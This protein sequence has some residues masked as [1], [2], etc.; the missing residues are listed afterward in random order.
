MNLTDYEGFLLEPVIGN[1]TFFGEILFLVPSITVLNC[2]L[3]NFEDK[4][5]FQHCLHALELFNH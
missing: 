5:N 4:I 3:V 2:N 1:L